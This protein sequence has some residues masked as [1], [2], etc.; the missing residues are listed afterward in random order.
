MEK[1][2]RTA[3][4]D[5]EMIRCAHASRYHWDQVGTAKNYAIGEWQ[6][7]RVYSILQMPESALYH[8]KRSL[9]YTKT[10]GVRF[11]DY[12]LP[13]VYEGLARA[14]ASAG[15]MRKARN[16]LRTAKQLAMKIKDAGDRKVALGEIA[17]VPIKL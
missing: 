10:R 2:R 14:Y 5:A 11:D 9:N 3:G 15:D 13:S 1:K 8:A 16:Y 4:E 17:S 7:A 6:L 12:Q